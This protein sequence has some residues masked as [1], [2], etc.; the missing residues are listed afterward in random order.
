MNAEKVLTVLKRTLVNK[1]EDI[2]E[3]EAEYE[4][5]KGFVSSEIKE[6]K[7]HLLDVLILLTDIESREEV[8]G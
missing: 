8:Q 6:K 1:Y 4:K 5:E 7:E 3:E 2:L